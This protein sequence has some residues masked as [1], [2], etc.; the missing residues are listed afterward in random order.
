MKRKVSRMGPASLVVSLPSKWVKKY[1]VNKGDEIDVEEKGSNLSISFERKSEEIKTTELDASG[2]YFSDLYINYCYRAGFDEIKVKYI[3]SYIF[4]KIQNRVNTLIGY[5]II[6]QKE[7]SCLIKIVSS[8]LNSEFESFFRKLLI[9]TLDMGE[10]FLNALKEGDVK[11]LEDIRLIEKTN[12]TFFE[13]IQKILHN[14]DSNNQRKTLSLYHIDRE[15]ERICDYY[16]Y[17]VDYVL[18]NKKE[19]ISARTIGFFEKVTK[20]VRD[21]YQLF[22]RYNLNKLHTLSKTRYD[23]IDFGY[24]VYEKANHVEGVII[25]HLILTVQIMFD[26]LGPLY[27]MNLSA[28]NEP[29][30]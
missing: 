15:F 18:K 13:F 24:K 1:G 2:D 28:S 19:K 23:L 10:S 25:M 3:D 7:N 30:L 8:P 21:F 22:Y 11:R 20:Y 5:E 14:E 6:D 27:I 16:K 17:M 4:N 12:N 29:T 26:L 9:T